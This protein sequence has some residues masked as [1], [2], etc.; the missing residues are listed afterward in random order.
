MII[1]RKPFE[2]ELDEKK[3]E[4]YEK[5]EE[6]EEEP[7]AI[8]TSQTS[9][10]AH[11]GRESTESL[12]NTSNLGNK[13]N[14]E[15][16]RNEEKSSREDSKEESDEVS[17]SENKFSDKTSEDNNSS[18]KNNEIVTKSEEDNMNN[19]NEET[20]ETVNGENNEE[21]NKVGDDSED[22]GED[23]SN[24]D[25]NNIDEDEG[26]SDHSNDSN[27]NEDNYDNDG[28][29][30]SDEEKEDEEDEN[31]SEE[32]THTYTYNT[33]QVVEICSENND[34]SL[35]YYQTEFYRFIEMIAEEKTKIFD[36]RSS[37]EYNIK[38]LMF[39]PFEKKPLNHYIQ[40]R[41]KDSVVLILDNSGSM[42]WWADNLM[43]LAKLALNRDDIE[44][45][46][47]P[48]GAIEDRLT[49]TRRISVSHDSIMKS[50]S[51]RKIIY[52]GDYDGANNPI[53]LSWRNEVVW[54]CPE[55]RYRRF[56]AHN[57]VKYS[58]YDFKGAFMRV[59]DLNEMF[60]AFKMLLSRQYVNGIWID[61]HENDKFDDD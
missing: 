31:E 46:I 14:A 24:E 42:N 8:P 12:P 20:N 36:Y 3:K 27:Y 13:E 60:H 50:L 61:L 15:K 11:G 25:E 4:G 18:E 9:E 47:A 49:K 5:H 48:N 53:E 16:R 29:E 32:Q 51:G 33:Q 10:N 39:R 28:E 54:I 17:Q 21:D 35:R 44:I 6:K 34:S 59:Y 56:N 57:W 55:S 43:I 23:Y 22:D 41:V 38:K 30:Y 2:I 37:E 1:V 40:S 45:Y 19:S 58:E 7:V 52:V 26:G